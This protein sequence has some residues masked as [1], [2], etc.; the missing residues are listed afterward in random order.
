MST[1]RAKSACGERE[2]RNYFNLE[3]RTY[4]TVVDGNVRDDSN[5]LYSARVRDRLRQI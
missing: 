3:D 4:L 2:V 1:R 5:L